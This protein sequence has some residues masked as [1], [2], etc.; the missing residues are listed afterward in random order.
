MQGTQGVSLVTQT[1]L[2]Q[3]GRDLLQTQWMS[4]LS[5]LLYL[6]TLIDQYGMN[7]FGVSMDQK[8]NIFSH[9]L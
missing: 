2:A 6:I 5:F 8:L 7:L 9:S 1:L 3:R 4:L